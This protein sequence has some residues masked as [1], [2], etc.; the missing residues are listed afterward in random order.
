M[1]TVDIEYACTRGLL[2]RGRS[3][4]RQVSGTVKVTT[5]STRS[6]PTVP[7]GHRLASLA[8]REIRGSP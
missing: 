7:D 5:S 4:A 6:T 2:R 8:V 1:V 3:D